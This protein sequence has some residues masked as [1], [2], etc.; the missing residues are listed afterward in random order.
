ME[1]NRLLSERAGKGDKNMTKIDK[2]NRNS[3]MGQYVNDKIN[4]KKKE[5]RNRSILPFEPIICIY[6]KYTYL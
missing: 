4:K 2:V 5:K 1:G 6:I 3:R